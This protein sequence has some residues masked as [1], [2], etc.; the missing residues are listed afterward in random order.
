M[1]ARHHLMPHE[2]C[3]AEKLA[4]RQQ[5]NRTPAII[6]GEQNYGPE[7]MVLYSAV[8]ANIVS[9]GVIAVLGIVLTWVPRAEGTLYE[10]ANILLGIAIIAVLAGMVRAFQGAKAGRAFRAG[11]PFIRP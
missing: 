4:E 6:R 8:L 1:N 5:S 10:I 2:R 9:A 11:R 3:R 7:G